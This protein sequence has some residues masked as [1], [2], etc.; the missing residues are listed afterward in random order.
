MIII[1]SGYLFVYCSWKIDFENKYDG[2][3]H[4][5]RSS[6]LTGY[7]M[8][9]NG[10]GNVEVSKRASLENRTIF[11]YQSNVYVTIPQ[12]YNLISIYLYHPITQVLI[13]NRIAIFFRFW[14][15]SAWKIIIIVHTN[16]MPSDI[17]SRIKIT[18]II[19]W[20]T[21]IFTIWL[22]FPPTSGSDKIT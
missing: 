15:A 1:V 20:E 7:G 19:Y 5:L 3:Y 17:P 4:F 8:R 21:N 22:I 9:T 12:I 18:R 10:V 6:C 14:E 13:K 11:W 16:G 2:C